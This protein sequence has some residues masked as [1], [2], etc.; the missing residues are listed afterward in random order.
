MVGGGVNPDIHD[1]PDLESLADRQ[2]H[3]LVRVS[4]ALELALFSAETIDHYFVDASEFFLLFLQL[5]LFKHINK[6][7]KAPHLDFL[8]NIVLHPAVGVSPLS[9]GVGEQIAHVVLYFLNQGQG[10]LKLSLSLTAKADYKV[11]TYSH[12]RN[13]LS[14]PID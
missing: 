12:S 5:V 4:E 1:I 6:L 7:A 13:L 2:D 8:W 14:Y 10:V 3:S 9:H 11:T